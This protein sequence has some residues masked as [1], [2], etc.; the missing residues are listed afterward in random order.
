MSTTEAAFLGLLFAGVAAL[1]A[2]VMLTR[3]NWR[4]DI[5][6]Y[7]L[8]TR[9]LDVTLHPDRYVKDAVLGVIR[10]LTFVGGVLL[11]CA[12]SLVAWEILQTMLKA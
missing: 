7:G 5:P 10:S 6:P 4:P 3:L 12:V 8:G 9:F 2:G 11:A 1:L